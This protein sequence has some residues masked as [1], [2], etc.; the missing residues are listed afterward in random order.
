M[1]LD[2]K[3]AIEKYKLLLEL[4]RS[5]NP[6]KTAKLQGIMIINSILVPS[7]VITKHSIFISI[8][9]FIVSFFWLF[10]LG[11]TIAFQHHWKTQ[12]EDIY[13]QYPDNPLFDILFRDRRFTFLEKVK[14]RYI[15]FGAIWISVAGWLV[16]LIWDICVV[17]LK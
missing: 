14:A 1:V 3:I 11:R 6:I 5:E 7:Y 16:L 2:E 13:R 15:L 17:I 4:W 8:I 12:I 9:G 10:S